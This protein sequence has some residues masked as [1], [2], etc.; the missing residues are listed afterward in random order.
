MN[1]TELRVRW[2]LVHER[3]RVLKC[4]VGDINPIN[5]INPIKTY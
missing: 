4:V 5:P 1:I 3:H 2:P